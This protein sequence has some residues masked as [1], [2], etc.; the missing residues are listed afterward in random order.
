MAKT[1][2]VYIC[3]SCGHETYRWMGKCPDC[4]GWNTFTEEIVES[5]KKASKKTLKTGNKP[6]QITQIDSQP[7]SRM[8]TDIQELDRVLGGGIVGGSVILIGGAPGMGKSTLLLQ[9]CGAL[10]L[11][12][13]NILYISGEESLQQIKL[14]ADRIHIGSDHFWLAAENDIT[15]I[16]KILEEQRPDLAVIDSIQ[17]V[18]FED[19]E[20]VPGNISQV[21]YC[22]HRLTSIAKQLG[23]PMFFVGHVTKEG[24]LAG[25]RVLEHLV[26]CLLFLEGDGQHQYRILRTI[27]NRFGSTNEVGLF[28]MTGQGISEVENPSAYLISQKQEN[29]SGTVVTITLEGTRPL[30]IE[31]QAL[32]TSTSFGIPQRTTTGFDHRRLTMMIAVLE[33]KIGLRFGNQDVFVNVAGGI[34][35][36]E[37]AVDLAIIAALVSSLREQPIPSDMAIVGEVGLTGEVRGVTQIEKRISEASRLGFK[38][39]FVPQSGL[40]KYKSDKDVQITGVQTVEQMLEEIF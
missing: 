7:E 14:R 21:R 13:K 2:T 4:D 39:L 5:S 25:P 35:L 24:S 1:R 17:T 37:P 31:V 27:K 16:V 38:K 32:V 26:D 15:M 18:Y 34:R 30:L 9:A 6:Q 20:S 22:G 29:T 12:G 19:M 36:Q 23:L 33:K 8:Q 10:A 3:Q 28:E 11:K 40:S